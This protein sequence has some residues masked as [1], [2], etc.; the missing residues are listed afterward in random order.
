V[1]VAL[2]AYAELA[3]EHRADIAR[4]PTFDLGVL[5]EARTLA[6]ALRSRSGE[7]LVRRSASE[8]GTRN[9]LLALLQDRLGRIRRCARLLFRDH[10]EIARRFS[11]HHERVGRKARRDRPS[12]Q[13]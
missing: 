13:A 6:H 8:L 7:A 10:P 11:S 12:T 4:L 5:D 9:Q 1:A 3:E 2:E